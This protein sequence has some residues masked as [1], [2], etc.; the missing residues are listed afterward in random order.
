MSLGITGPGGAAATSA[1]DFTTPPHLTI[2]AADGSLLLNMDGD[3]C[4][5]HAHFG[6]HKAPS[7]EDQGDSEAGPVEARRPDAVLTAECVGPPM[8]WDASGY[9][10]EGCAARLPTSV[11][12]L[13]WF[14]H[15]LATPLRFR[16][17]QAGLPTVRGRALAHFEKNWGRTF[18]TGWYW[19][20]GVNTTGRHRADIS[21][22]G[23]PSLHV[24]PLGMPASLQSVQAAFVLAGGRLPSPLVPENWL[25]DLWL[26]GV[27]TP[28]RSWDLHGGMDSIITA[29]ADPCRA[30]LLV[31]ATQPLLR[32]AVDVQITARPVSFATLEG[33][34]RSGF[35]PYLNESLGAFATVRLFELRIGPHQRGWVQKVLVESFEVEGA[36]LEFGGD[37]RCADKE[38]AQAGNVDGSAATL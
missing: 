17:E 20:Q 10:P 15:S 9:G 37:R 33:P 14:V 22:G 3:S 36:A 19:A 23:P 12:G 21:S 11:T 27:R 38:G 35:R 34:T 31:S 26:L 29:Q 24:P 28:N 8:L 18:P 1:P 7:A 13:H 32:R 2:A 25:P 6:G 16:L 5:L 30:A 4:R